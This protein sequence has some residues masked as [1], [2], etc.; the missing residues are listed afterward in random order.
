MAVGL[1]RKY[2]YSREE[3]IAVNNMEKAFTSILSIPVV[4]TIESQ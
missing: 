3:H 1:T 2:A 4:H